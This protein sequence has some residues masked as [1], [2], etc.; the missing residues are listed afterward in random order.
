LEILETNQTYTYSSDGVSMKTKQLMHL[1]Q[2]S[3]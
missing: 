3:V 1:Q 2:W